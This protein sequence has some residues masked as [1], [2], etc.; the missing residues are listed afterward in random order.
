MTPPTGDSKTV[1]RISQ[2]ALARQVVEGLRA[3]REQIPEYEPA[4][5]AMPYLIRN[6]AAMPT[7]FLDTAA[8]VLDGSELIRNAAPISADRIRENI[9]FAA[10]FEAVAEEAEALARAVRFV[11]ARRRAEAA[12]AAMIVY[13]VAK[14]HS[15]RSDSNDL[16]AAAKELQRALGKSSVA[17]RAT[18]R[19][20]DAAA[21]EE[22]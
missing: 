6:R 4:P 20:A 18:A 9:A 8:S 16:V 17:R 11:Q 12:A 3:L 22:R 10:A 14:I 21:S 2:S 5:A 13:D 15:K 7:E 1:T 19:G